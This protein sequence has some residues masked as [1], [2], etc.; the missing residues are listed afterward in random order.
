MK[1]GALSAIFDAAGFVN[2]ANS[3]PDENIWTN[4]I[5]D[6]EGFDISRK[7]DRA[8][9]IAFNVLARI[10]GVLAIF[11]GIVFFFSAYAFNEY[12]TLD[13]VVGLWVTAMGIAFLLAK[14]FTAEQLARIRLRIGRPR[15]S[16]SGR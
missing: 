9:L 4:P 11:V 8:F 16:E 7:F 3:A 6:R 2:C 14:P 13:I 5:V 15:S 1:D 12:R 10:F